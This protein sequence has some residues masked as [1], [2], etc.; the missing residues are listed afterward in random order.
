MDLLISRRPQTPT[1]CFHIL[2]TGVKWNPLFIPCFES[3]WNSVWTHW[4]IHILIPMVFNNAEVFKK[5]FSKGIPKRVHLRLVFHINLT[6]GT[7][8]ANSLI[9]LLSY[10]GVI[11]LRR[12]SSFLDQVMACRLY[13]DKLWFEP[14]LIVITEKKE[15]PALLK[16]NP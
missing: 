13:G 14:Q 16:K 6:F 11:W 7:Y 5:C 1:V 3:F 12:L 4:T 8:Q 9:N 10:S 15:W 2:K